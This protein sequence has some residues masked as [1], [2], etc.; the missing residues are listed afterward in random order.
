MSDKKDKDAKPK[1]KGGKMMLILGAVGLLAVGGGGVFGLV[2]TGVIG[3]SH[4]APKKEDKNPKLIRKGEEDP[5]APKAKEGEG[6]GGG[7]EVDCLLYTSPSP[8]DRSVS[9]MPS[10]A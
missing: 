6:E 4:A 5:F 7:K 1:K 3:G 9:R 8:R 10:S 2:A